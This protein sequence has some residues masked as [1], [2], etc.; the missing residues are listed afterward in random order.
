MKLTILILL[1]L[2]LSACTETAKEK[3]LYQQGYNEG[4][5][6]AKNAPTEEVKNDIKIDL[7]RLKSGNGDEVAGARGAM[8]ATYEF[9]CSGTMVFN[10][11]KRGSSREFRKG[12]FKG[13]EDGLFGN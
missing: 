13:C 12:Y 4:R 8:Q 7:K 1:L 3:T 9:Y 11:D 10:Y 2:T 5:D 6:F